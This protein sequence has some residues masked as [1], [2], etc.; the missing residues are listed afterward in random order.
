MAADE[1]RRPTPRKKAKPA[2]SAGRAKAPS[3]PRPSRPPRARA[4]GGSSPVPVRPLATEPPK[5]PAAAPRPTAS[6]GREQRRR[7]QR[8]RGLRVALVALAAAVALA[9]VAGLALLLLRDSSVFEITNVEAEATEHVSET[10]IANLVQVPVG[11]T[12]LNVDTAAIEQ[13][14]L[15]DP[16]VA[17]VSFERVFP[18]TLR[19]VIT[20]QTP[21]MLVVMGSGSVAWYLGDAGVWIQP[22]TI[23]AADDQSVSDAALEVALAEGCLLV[24]DVPS[25][26]DPVAGSEATDE[27]LE[28]VKAFREGFSDEF[29][30][31]VVCFSAPSVDN[32]SCVLAN[33]VEVS[34]GSASNVS[35]KEAIVTE[36]LEEYPDTAI[37]INVRVVTNPSVRT[38]SS[39]SVEAGSGIVATDAGD[40][41]ADATG[42]T[43]TD[44]TDGSGAAETSSGDEASDGSAE[45]A[46]S[47]LDEG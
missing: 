38:I 39:E 11:S 21:D 42:T 14:L 40:T 16:W 30:E 7:H 32:V 31:Q 34:L 29:N 18:D 36:Y 2:A 47:E 5:A 12:L 46:T 1:S 10:D 15:R 4:R 13:A 41:A 6:S 27:V 3:R 25:T 22:T 24:T 20:E 17:S 26:V 43:G 33:G 44:A 19:L 35:E 28:A 37:Y 8:A 23:N 45:E 9:L